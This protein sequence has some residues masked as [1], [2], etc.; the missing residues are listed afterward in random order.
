MTTG[1][2][3]GWAGQPVSKFLEKRIFCPYWELNPGPYILSCFFANDYPTSSYLNDRLQ[4]FIGLNDAPVKYD[5]LL[6]CLKCNI[7]C[8]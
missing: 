4:K 6:S 7:S 1:E 3:S 5:M 2:S 8:S